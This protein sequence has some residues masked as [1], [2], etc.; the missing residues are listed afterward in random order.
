MRN[1][2]QTLILAIG[3]AIYAV[4]AYLIHLR[5]FPVGDLGVESDFYA[6]LA[7][8]AQ[9]LTDGQFAV[10][11]YP[12]KGP[13]YSFILTALHFVMQ[14]LGAQW[15]DTAVLL[16]ALCAAAS[17]VVLFLLLRNLFGPGLATAATI[18]TAL[19]IEF[20]LHAQKASSDLLYLLL[21]LSTVLALMG[22]LTRARVLSAGILAGMA[23]LTR[24][25]GGV[26][27]AAGVVAL[28]LLPGVGKVR[29]RMLFAVIFGLGFLVVC[30]PWFIINVSTTGHFLNDGNLMNVVL[31][32]YSGERAAQV[33]DGGFKSGWSLASQDP[34]YF[35]SHF[36]ANIPHHF[37][38][39]MI[40]L[41]GVRAWFLVVMGLAGIL[42]SFLPW[43]KTRQFFRRRR[44]SLKQMVFFIIAGISFLAMCLVFHRPRFSLPLVPAYF[45]LGY[46]GIFGF[47][48]LTKR[49]VRDYRLT[50]LVATV[51]V[52]AVS[53]FQVRDIIR[54]EQYY[55]LNRPLYVLEQAPGVRALAGES[56]SRSLLARKPHLAHYS[57]LDPV[58]YPTAIHSWD[59]FFKYAL[60]RKVDL[61]AVGPLERAVLGETMILDY[62]DR[63]P[64]ITRLSDA[65]DLIIYHLNREMGVKAF[66]TDFPE[67]GDRVVAATQTGDSNSVCLA[68]FEWGLALMP[69]AQWDQAQLQ[70]TCCL[71]M[72]AGNPNVIRQKDKDYLR[73]NL[74][75]IH[76]KTDDP[77]GGIALLGENFA[78]LGPEDDPYLQ[79]LRHFVMGRLQSA[80]GRTA[81]ARKNFKIAHSAY[82]KA[83]NE[84]AIQEVLQHLDYLNN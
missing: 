7:V 59:Q 33:P 3:S 17:I 43:F 35:L 9:R 29:Q 61:I 8:S 36:L 32:F 31:E 21:F 34:K 83:G 16:N 50:I 57:G 19:C 78:Q 75:F 68:R 18:S 25:S 65:D 67:F 13:L 40:Q 5:W 4:M 6:E 20:F 30:L 48:S 72:V 55:Y 74:A 58:A 69:L 62:L 42:F 38:Q 49:S 63:A 11:N 71:E 15:Y 73:V 70:L 37:K 56:L 28:G 52:L 22:K 26:L 47:V 81:E 46:G 1:L 39:D 10:S 14:P 84:A 76:L 24:Y 82:V 23:F 79:G 53:N 60:D 51:V 44:P 41:V 54:G 66:A 64:G 45:V 77:A 12:F 27:I 80:L 2:H